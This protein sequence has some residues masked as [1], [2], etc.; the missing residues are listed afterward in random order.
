[1]HGVGVIIA[2]IYIMGRDG[3]GPKWL[4]AE[5]VMEHPLTAGFYTFRKAKVKVENILH[6]KQI[7]LFF[8]MLS[9]FSV[10]E[11]EERK[12]SLVL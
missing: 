11:I 3:H 6:D 8:K 1:M 5:M 4:W 7:S 2:I 10:Y 12:C 9:I